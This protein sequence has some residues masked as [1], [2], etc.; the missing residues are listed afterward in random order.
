MTSSYNAEL[1]HRLTGTSDIKG[2]IA[3]YIALA[4]RA[5]GEVLELGAG[6]GRTL[7]PLARE[8]ITI[9]GIEYD[10]GM[11]KKLRAL[12]SEEPEDVRARIM[13]HEGDMR[14][15][16]LKTKTFAMVQL[17]FRALLHC[18][19]RDTQLACLRCCHAHLRPGGTLALNVFF[20]SLRYMSTYQG[21]GEG[22]WRLI[23][24]VEGD[25]GTFYQSSEVAR[26]DTVKQ[27]FSARLRTEHFDAQGD[28]M[29][30]SVQRLEL[31]FLYP[32]DIVALLE[33]AGFVDITLEPDFSPGSLQNEQQELAVHAVRA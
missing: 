32:Q 17:P 30:T 9:S 2:D 4:E 12:V 14:D 20:P 6:T 29:T 7:I 26:Y 23:N 31:A 16:A 8:G 11:L 25:H 10:T 1:Y 21:M 5:H 27:R 13:L 15:F 3:W 24:E 28:L 33:E 22:V 19:D 18:L